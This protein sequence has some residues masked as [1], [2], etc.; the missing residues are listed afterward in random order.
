VTSGDARKV[1]PSDAWFATTHWSA[2]LTAACSDTTRARAALEKLCQ[3]YWYPLYAY[4]RRRGHSPPDAEDL[5]QGFF[6]RLLKLNS[7]ADVR[8]EKG[9]FRAFLLA[10]MNHYLADEWDRAR[11]QRRDVR[12]TISLDTG[13]AETRYRREPADQLTPERLFERQWALTLLETV[14][15]RL[16]R[17]YEADGKGELFMQLRF[18]ITGD[19]SAVPYTDL[20]ARIGMSEE[21]VRVAVH[22]LR[23]RY[24]QLLR[25]EIAHTVTTEDEVADELRSLRRILSS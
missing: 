16:H 20:A 7:L 8:R 10:S 18:A 4:A 23:R 5:T 19:K 2:V 14:V 25:E 13:A 15:Q 17:E 12:R 3:T 11:A 9:K 1:R 24:R 21:A 6:A 22:R